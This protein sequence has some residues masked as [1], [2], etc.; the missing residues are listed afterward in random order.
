MNFAEAREVVKAHPK[1]IGGF[2]RAKMP[3]GA[4]RRATKIN[5]VKYEFDS[6][7]GATWRYGYSIGDGTVYGH[8]I[9]QHGVDQPNLE[10]VLDLHRDQE[11]FTLEVGALDKSARTTAGIAG[12]PVNLGC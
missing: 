2:V 6:C 8:K 4:I 12:N 3:S 1:R 11:F 7:T 10:V 5:F 9:V